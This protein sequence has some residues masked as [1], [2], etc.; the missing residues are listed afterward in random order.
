MKEQA[1]RILPPPRRKQ[2]DFLTYG[3]RPRG[4]ISRKEDWE[5][6]LE[7]IKVETETSRKEAIAGFQ[8]RTRRTLP[9]EDPDVR[10]HQVER[11][12]QATHRKGEKTTVDICFEG[13]VSRPWSVFW[14]RKFMTGKQAKT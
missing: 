7:G 1:L 11:E 4:I 6:Y 9:R 3:L 10:R 13:P 2:T 8:V 14:A 5:S 12:M